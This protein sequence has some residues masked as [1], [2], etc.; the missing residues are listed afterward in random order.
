MGQN[1]KIKGTG[2]RGAPKKPPHLKLVSGTDRADRIDPELIELTDGADP[3]APD[4]L[5][6][7]EKTTWADTVE[8]L[9]PMGLLSGVDVS[10]MV[11]YCISVS[12]VKTAT[13]TI[14]AEGLYS[15]TQ[16][17]IPATHPA[18][19]IRRQAMADMVSYAI[20]MGMTP[21]A[22]L[23]LNATA[24]PKKK[25]NPFDKLKNSD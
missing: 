22:R 12:T 25:E 23:R 14:A 21:A 6:A 19:I 7:D 3:A 9:R 16:A 8:L 2:R 10:L 17:G 11:A 20:Q 5:G 24:A 1:S 4:Y 18:V 15:A 13:G